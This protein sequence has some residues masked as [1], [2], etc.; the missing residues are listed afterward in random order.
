MR[1][2]ALAMGGVL[3]AV[4]GAELAAGSLQIFAQNMT[5]GR[6]FMAFAAGVFGAGHPIG[7]ALA[8]L[9]FSLV[10]ALGIRAQLLWGDAVPPDLLLALPYLATV[11]GVW[12]SGRLRGGAQA[13]AGFAELRDY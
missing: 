11:L 9:F 12:L 8:A 4:G 10:G 2:L 6:G 1:L 7:A 5:A 13:A 3:C